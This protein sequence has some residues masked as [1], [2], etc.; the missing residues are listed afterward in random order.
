VDIDEAGHENSVF[1]AVYTVAYVLLQYFSIGPAA[2]ITPA[3]YNSAIIT[4][5]VSSFRV[6]S[7]C[8]VIIIII[9]M[10]ADATTALMECQQWIC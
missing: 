3:E 4:G 5:V 1:K 10:W 2:S 8:E 9:E 7:F 6:S